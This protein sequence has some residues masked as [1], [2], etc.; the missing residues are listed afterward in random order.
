V[1]RRCDIHSPYTQSLLRFLPQQGLE[2]GEIFR[3]AAADVQRDTGGTQKPEYL[4]QTS[5]ALF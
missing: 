1:R 3:Q 4:V 2:V 5:R